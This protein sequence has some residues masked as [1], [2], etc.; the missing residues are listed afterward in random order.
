[1]PQVNDIH[2]EE[3]QLI[4]GHA[5]SWVVRCGVTIIFC[6]F[7]ITVIACYFIKY[8]QTVTAPIL[9]TTINPPS[10]LLAR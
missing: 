8:P 1:M 10:D 9:I 6:I 2:C 5:P 4:M 3:I 7:A